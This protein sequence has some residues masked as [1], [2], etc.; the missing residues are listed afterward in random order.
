MVMARSRRSGHV[1]G[2]RD[3]CADT[4]HT[5]L[6]HVRCKV[7]TRTKLKIRVTSPAIRRK[8]HRVL[9]YKALLMSCLLARPLDSAG[10]SFNSEGDQDCTSCC[11]AGSHAARNG[12]HAALN[13]GHAAR[14]GCH[15]AFASSARAQLDPADLS[16]SP[17]SFQFPAPPPSRGRLGEMLNPNS[18]S[19]VTAR[20][21][22]ARRRGRLFRRLASPRGDPG[23]QGRAD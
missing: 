20:S 12:C 11:H 17:S 21:H 6:R 3:G 18:E 4:A 16:E 13:G 2:K 14:N 22:G 15:A 19:S 5:W 8:L 23:C 7:T 9:N 10:L 1:V